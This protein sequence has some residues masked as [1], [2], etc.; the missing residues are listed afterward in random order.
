[1]T[2]E[3]LRFMGL[4]REF[5]AD[6][7]RPW[8]KVLERLRP[9][10]IEAYFVCGRGAGKSRIVAL[11]GCF[12]A[13]RRYRRAAGEAIIIGIIAP[14]KAQAVVTFRYTRALLKAH[15]TLAGL[16]VNETADTLRLSTGTVVEVMSAGAWSARGRSFGAIVVEEGAFL[17][18]DPTAANQDTEL[19][20]SVRP[21][22][23]RV[24]GSRLIVVSS[25]FE[26]RGILWEAAQ[27]YEGKPDDGL[28]L[29][30]RA[31]TLELNPTFDKAAIDRAYREDPVSAACEFG[32]EFRIDGA[33][34]VFTSA[35]LEAVTVRRRRELPPVVDVAYHGFVDL[36]GGGEGGDSAALAIAHTEQRRGGLVAVV[37]VVRMVAPP[38]SVTDVCSEFSST[39]RA[40]D[41]S[42]VVGDQFGSRFAEQ[43]MSRAGVT[44]WPSDRSCSVLY[45]E[46]LAAVNSRQV[47]LLD[48][49]VLQAQLGALQ[50]RAGRSGREVVGHPVGQHDDVSNA[51][52]GAV[53]EALQ[54]GGSAAGVGRARTSSRDE[55]L[56][57]TEPALSGTIR[58]TQARRPAASP[59][60]RK[61]KTF[62]HEGDDPDVDMST[63]PPAQDWLSLHGINP[64]GGRR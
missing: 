9:G 64:R 45:L 25:P 17:D 35:A 14:S 34:C 52:A 46:L 10:V 62:D 58:R 44:L 20:R 50:R 2:S 40:Y 37:D 51:V 15:P 28:H 33:A 60:V 18:T 55:E 42:L 19:V 53:S 61:V 12:H 8:R 3:L 4:F 56:E 54:S 57:P 16:I 22:L 36:A 23:A 26:R 39:A 27:K 38:F 31:T 49:D 11:L 6:S 59:N 43:E 7:W 30:V 32:G 48:V 24:P 5:R 21:G 47:E 1:M 29:F 13:T 41:I 63:L